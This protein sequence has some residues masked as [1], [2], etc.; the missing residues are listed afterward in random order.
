VE[1]IVDCWVNTRKELEEAKNTSH[2]KSQGSKEGRMPSSVFR[3]A[4]GIHR[5][6]RKYLG[7][8]IRS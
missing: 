6:P 7:L 3:A 1:K 2:W 5:L 4:K 8:L